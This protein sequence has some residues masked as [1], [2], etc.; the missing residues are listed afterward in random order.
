MVGSNPRDHPA[1]HPQMCRCARNTPQIMVYNKIDKLEGWEPQKDPWSRTLTNTW[2]TYFYQP[3]SPITNHCHLLVSIE[4]MCTGA[5]FFRFWVRFTIGLLDWKKSPRIE[6]TR[7]S[8]RSWVSTDTDSKRQSQIQVDFT[9]FSQ[10]V[11]WHHVCMYIDMYIYIYIGIVGFCLVANQLPF[12][13]NK[14]NEK[15]RLLPTR[16]QVR[17][18]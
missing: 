1:V 7:R 9:L 11:A 6:E 3:F 15:K 8:E 5:D 17:E 12:G 13:M 18:L 10:W 16:P 2:G 14:S 4:F